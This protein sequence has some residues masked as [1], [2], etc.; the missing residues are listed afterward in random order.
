[1]KI[2]YEGYYGFKNAGDDAFV[3]VAA[4]GGK[5]YWDCSNNY[6][7]GKSLPKTMTPIKSLKMKPNFKGMDRMRMLY[8][9]IGTD[10]FI[11]AG[12]ST[13]TEV[14]FHSNKILAKH[15]SVHTNLRLGAIGV[16]I[17]PFENL[18]VEKKVGAYLKSLKFLTLRDKISY[19]YAVN[20][21]LPYKPVQ[22][23][24]LAALLPQIYNFNK[25]KKESTN[26]KI[27]GVSICNY[28]RYRGKPL[29]KERKRFHFFQE[30]LVSLSENPQ[31]HFK[32]F[33]F[34]AHPKVG[35]SQVTENLIEKLPEKRLTIIP[36]QQE[37]KKTWMDV[38]SC[39]CMISTRMHASIFACYSQ[40]P[41]F[42]IEYHRKCTDFLNDVGQAEQYRFYDAEIS[43]IIAA[44]KVELV[45]YE[46]YIEPTNIEKTISLAKKNFDRK[47]VL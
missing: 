33:I 45:L 36:Y 47:L 38:A 23:F 19:D 41:F 32:V 10:Y 46:D 34:N 21:H 18:L 14:P 6:F 25:I 44:Q 24:D 7:F 39:D 20:L 35:D 37:I 16:S 9:L 27:V 43:P 15:F 29:H 42:L 28:E 31:I 22:A 12:G 13:F 30:L 8:S 11:S 1:M 2:I 3:E 5:K 40:V 4:W 26:K 17:G